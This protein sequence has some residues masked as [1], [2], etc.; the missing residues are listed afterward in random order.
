MSNQCNTC[1][2]PRPDALRT[3]IT[4]ANLCG[5][6]CES[7]TDNCQVEECA[8]P[9]HLNGMCVHYTG[10]QTFLTQLNPGTTFDE[11]MIKIENLFNQIDRLLESYKTRMVEMQNEIEDLKDQLATGRGCENG[12]A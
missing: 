3:V 10:C 2:D 8:C 1:S 4:P 7:C 5:T 6:E 12:F 11:A 9:V